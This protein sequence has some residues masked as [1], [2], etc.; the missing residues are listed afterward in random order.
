MSVFDC[1][2]AVDSLLC[3]L[4]CLRVFEFYSCEMWWCLSCWC[5]WCFGG[6]FAC[7]GCVLGSF[8][9][10]FMCFLVLS[11]VVACLWCV[12]VFGGCLLLLCCGL[13]CLLVCV[14]VVLFV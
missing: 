4:R 8:R 14:V 2:F 3:V 7:L 1:L 13:C 10:V 11:R 6:A 9:F 12:G 5:V